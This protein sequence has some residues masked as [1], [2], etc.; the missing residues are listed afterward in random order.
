MIL[1][2]FGVVQ[3]TYTSIIVDIDREV[4]ATTQLMDELTRKEYFKSTINC[5]RDENE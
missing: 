3:I 2:F 5:R 1:V 4:E